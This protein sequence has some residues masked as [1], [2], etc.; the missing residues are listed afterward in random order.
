MLE[1]I[2]VPQYGYINIADKGPY[3]VGDADMYGDEK[4]GTVVNRQNQKMLER[5]DI[6]RIWRRH[7]GVYELTFMDW[8]KGR[9][10]ME[11]DKT[12]LPIRFVRVQ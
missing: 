12:G 5:N 4:N 1:D 6:K 2:I 3:Q 8:T 7:N 10:K 11:A 9:F